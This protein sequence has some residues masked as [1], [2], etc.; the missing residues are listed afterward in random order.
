MHGA[1]CLHLLRSQASAFLS[2]TAPHDT[3]PHQTLTQALHRRPIAC[4]SMLPTHKPC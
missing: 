1:L 3:A 2:G 4:L